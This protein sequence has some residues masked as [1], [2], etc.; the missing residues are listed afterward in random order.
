MKTYKKQYEEAKKAKSVKILTPQLFKFTPEDN[1]IIGVFVSRSLV[2]DIE[3]EGG[4][5][6][7]VFETDEGLIKFGA[8]SGFDADAGQQLAHGILY[9]VEYLGQAKTSKGRT[10]NKYNTIEVG[11]AEYIEAEPGD[12]ES[13]GK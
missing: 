12:T 13:D 3:G 2:G 8:G 5:Y 9:M 10:V 6:Q 1:V 11:K 4:Y 7:Y